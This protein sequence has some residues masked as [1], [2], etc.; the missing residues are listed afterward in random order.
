LKISVPSRMLSISIDVE[1]TPVTTQMAMIVA[2][3]K[4][5][6]ARAV[7]GSTRDMAMSTRTC[8]LVRNRCGAM[9]NVEMNR[10]Y[11]VSSIRPMIEGKLNIRRM[12]SALTPSAMMAITRTASTHRMRTSHPLTQKIRR[13]RMLRTP[14]RRA[15]LGSFVD[16]GP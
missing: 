12:T 4:Y 11:S 1:T 6:N 5:S 15:S 7:A 14:A 3:T 16:D 10:P 9:K 13:M 8:S 2:S